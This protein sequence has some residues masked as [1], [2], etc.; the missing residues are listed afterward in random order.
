[1][2]PLWVR[3]ILRQHDVEY[4]N[5]I[6]EVRMREVLSNIETNLVEETGENKLTLSVG[7]A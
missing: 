2:Y 1:M 5:V 4:T 7:A 6:V 3:S